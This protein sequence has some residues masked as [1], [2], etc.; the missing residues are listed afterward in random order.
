VKRLALAVTLALGACDRPPLPANETGTLDP[1][2]F[3]LGMSEGHGRLHTVIGGSEPLRVRSVGT[4]DGDDALVLKQSIKQGGKPWRQRQW[5]MRRLGPGRF[6]GTLTDAAS[7]VSVTVTGPRARIRYRMKG[8]FEV[9]QQLALQS[10]ES[11]CNRLVV[12]K[13]GIRVAWVNETI[14]RR[15]QL[16]TGGRA[17]DPEPE[18]AA[19]PQA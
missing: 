6:T 14:V 2:T 3:F 16:P 17:G 7:P 8:G 9:D 15:P 12:R 10:A 18:P 19:C 1:L 13:F 11:L 5:V 4:R